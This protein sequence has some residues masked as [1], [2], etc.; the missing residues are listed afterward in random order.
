[1]HFDK[2]G[3]L[4]I[5]T[6]TLSNEEQCISYIPTYV[7]VMVYRNFKL[8]KNYIEASPL[9]SITREQAAFILTHGKFISILY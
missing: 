9:M 1:M 7:V 6:V 2:K 3:N 4:V 5:Q 8:G